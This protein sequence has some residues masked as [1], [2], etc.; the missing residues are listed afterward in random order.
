MR[1]TSQS[2]KIDQKLNFSIFL[3]NLI[4]YFICSKPVFHNL[5]TVKIAEKTTTTTINDL[6]VKKIL[7]KVQLKFLT[8]FGSPCT[9]VGACARQQTAA[10]YL[11]EMAL[12]VKFVLY[13]Y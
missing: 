8:H 6:A 3:K 11:P 12:E 7:K 4:F 2:A 10:C 9:L 1:R 13:T 5:K